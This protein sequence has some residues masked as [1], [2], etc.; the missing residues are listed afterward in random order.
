[1]TTEIVWRCRGCTT[2]IRIIL[3]GEDV[4]RVLKTCFEHA[5]HHEQVCPKSRARE[6]NISW[7]VLIEVQS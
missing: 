6:G 7:P 3:D 5:Q 2:H 4:Q 1:M